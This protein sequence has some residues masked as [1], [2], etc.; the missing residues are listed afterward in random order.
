MH[1]KQRGVTLIG[2]L[3]LLLP[4]AIVVYAGIRLAPVYLNYMK[5]VHSM[6]QIATELHADETSNVAAI[7]TALEKHLDIQSV[8]YPEIK[9]FEIRRDGA[10]WIVQSAYEETAP[11][12][13]NISIVVA[14]DKT[15]RIQ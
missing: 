6:D 11:L 9:D 15:V 12:F 14:F 4:I 13:S 2:W 5:V 3:F 10:V 8:T 7:R 1:S